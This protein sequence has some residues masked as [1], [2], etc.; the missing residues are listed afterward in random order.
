M[1]KLGQAGRFGRLTPPP[2]R[3][4]R[5]VIKDLRYGYWRDDELLQHL[6]GLL[7]AVTAVHRA[8]KCHGKLDVNNVS[9]LLITAQTI[10]YSL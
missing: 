2:L 6:A 3:V 4:S 10:S 7:R 8:K 9:E 1:R 5:T